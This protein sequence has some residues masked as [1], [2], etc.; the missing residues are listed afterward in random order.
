MVFRQGGPSLPRGWRQHFQVGDPVDEAILPRAEGNT[1]A[2][3]DAVGVP[4][5]AVRALEGIPA[6]SQT[7]TKS[8]VCVACDMSS[9]PATVQ[10]AGGAFLGIF[11]RSNPRPTGVDQNGEIGP[12]ALPGDGSAASGLPRSK[13]IATRAACSPPAENP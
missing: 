8:I 9:M 6:F 2:R 5:V 11:V 10:K 4:S 13:F 7:E 1:V 12:V 3:F